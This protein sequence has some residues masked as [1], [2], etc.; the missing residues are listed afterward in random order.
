MPRNS[1]STAVY[2]EDNRTIKTTHNGHIMGRKIYLYA[3]QMLQCLQYIWFNGLTP[4]SHH[5]NQRFLNYVFEIFS[6]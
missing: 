5:L 2:E 3:M 6:M 1:K 4:H